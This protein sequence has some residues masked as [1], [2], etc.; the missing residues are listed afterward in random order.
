MLDLGT[1]ASRNNPGRPRPSVP[2]PR[3]EQGSRPGVCPTSSSA[4]MCPPRG[5][6]AQRRWGGGG[7]TYRGSGDVLCSSR[8]R[9]TWRKSHK[10]TVAG[11]ES[12]DVF[13][14]AESHV[15]FWAFSFDM[16]P[17]S[18]Y[19]CFRTIFVSLR[20]FLASILRMAQDVSLLRSA[21]LRCVCVCGLKAVEKYAPVAN[22]LNWV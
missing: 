3:L 13:S 18:V 1:C 14:I 17:N 15:F 5:Q 4:S 20:V 12:Q 8:F 22:Y 6:R 21:T 10:I 7:R 11:S 9:W 16:C 2:K 19:I